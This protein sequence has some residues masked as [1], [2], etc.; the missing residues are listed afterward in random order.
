M[1]ARGGS[2]QGF[3][4]AGIPSDRQWQNGGVAERPRKLLLNPQPLRVVSRPAPPPMP[5]EQAAEID[6]ATAH[7][8]GRDHDRANCFK[9]QDEDDENPA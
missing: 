7:R 2:G 6:R 8:L 9:C 3:P 5:P 4:V 1:L